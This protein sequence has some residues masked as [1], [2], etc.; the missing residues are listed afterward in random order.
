MD[1]VTITLNVPK[2]V[3]AA[4][5]AQGLLEEDA[6]ALFLEAALW[7]K[8][9]ADEIERGWD[10]RFANSMDVLEAMADEAL[11]EHLAGNSLPIECD[12]E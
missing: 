12:D 6:L 3:A 1:T 5:E 9:L 2:S 8:E 10:E 7:D 4:L 11:A